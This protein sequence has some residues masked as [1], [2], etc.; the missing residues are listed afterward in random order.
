[1]NAAAV[2]DLCAAEIPEDH[3]HVADL[4]SRRLACSCRPCAILFEASRGGRWR[5]VPERVARC[6]EVPLGDD[7]W[8]AL[9]IPVDLAFF[10]RTGE[11][12]RIVGF[13]P[14]PSGATE[15]ALEGGSGL[16]G[17][18]AALRGIEP[19]VEALLV[20]RSRGARECWIVPVDRCYALVGLIRSHWTGLGGGSEV[21]TRIGAFFEGLEARTRV[22]AREEA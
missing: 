13:Y 21:W 19:D 20:N 2:C 15:A 8:T 22:G 4:H 12:D 3:R 16:D 7:A 10:L 6:P 9:G 11:D 1:M 5:T 14:G 17:L 18:H